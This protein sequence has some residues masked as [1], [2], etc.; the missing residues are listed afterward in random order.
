MQAYRNNRHFRFQTVKTI[1]LAIAFL[2]A[3]LLLQ[4]CG[5]NDFNY[6]KARNLIEG[7]PMHLDAEYVMLS[8]AEFQCGL[9]EELWDPL[10]QGVIVGMIGQTGTARLTQKGRDLKFSD[11]V[12]IGDKRYP[13]VQVRGDLSLGVLEITNDKAGSDEFT[14]LVEAKLG[15]L[16][17]YSC[18]PN[19]LTIM[20]V[21][22]GQFTQDAS[23]ILEFR[24]NNGWSVEKIVH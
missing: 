2:P 4:S 9:Q 11:D 6:G 24:Y 10:P 20:G 5:P 14:R 23:P 16:I 17:P 7:S 8:A 13:Y 19:P 3:M 12:M 22:K 18:F 21:R 1:A 15:V